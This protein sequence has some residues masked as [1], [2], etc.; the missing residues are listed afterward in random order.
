MPKVR[1]SGLVWGARRE[2]SGNRRASGRFTIT[3]GVGGFDRSDTAFGR[4]ALTGANG[5]RICVGD[6]SWFPV[7][8]V[9]L[10]LAL[11]LQFDEGES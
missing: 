10:T 5:S 2:S 7:D 6:R 8:S 11:A 9:W 4:R 1:A 3:R